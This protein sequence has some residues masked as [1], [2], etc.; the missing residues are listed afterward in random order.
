MNK[1]E[2][3]SQM[4]QAVGLATTFKPGMVMRPD[5]PVGMMQGVAE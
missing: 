3:M 4:T 1:E 2:E 5:D